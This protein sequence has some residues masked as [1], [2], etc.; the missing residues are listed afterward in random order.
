MPKPPKL[1]HLVLRV[2]DLERSEM[3]YTEVLGLM[4]TGRMPGAMTFFTGDG[5]ESH[6]LGIMNVG[7]DA[8]GPEPHRAGLYHFAYQVE[9]MDELK[10][11]YHHLKEKEVRI[12]GMGDHG[13][14]K[15]VYFLDPDD[16]EIEVFYE[17]PRSE[18]PDPE[19]PLDNLTVKPLSLE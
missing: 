13:I 19:R 1:S 15:G 18:W 4:V 9:S 6:T 8:P 10:T 2:R 7:P 12:V 14:S 16:N 3:F 17:L 11:F 5:E